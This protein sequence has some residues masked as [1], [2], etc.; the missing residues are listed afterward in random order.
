MKKPNIKKELEG[1]RNKD[2]EVLIPVGDVI[3]D[4]TYVRVIPPGT[5]CMAEFKRRQKEQFEKIFEIH[6]I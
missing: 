6:L 3:Y 5:D 2:G 4:I 1:F